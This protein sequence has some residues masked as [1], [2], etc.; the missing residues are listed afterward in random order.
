MHLVLQLN[1]DKILHII[2]ILNII[3]CSEFVINS[4]SPHTAILNVTL[5]YD[6]RFLPTGNLSQIPI[7]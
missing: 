4:S 3:T 7:L 5:I 6:A 1:L 2:A